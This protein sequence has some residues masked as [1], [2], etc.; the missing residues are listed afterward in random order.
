MPCPRAPPRSSAASASPRGAARFD[1]AF[2]AWG[3]SCGV[4]WPCQVPARLGPR[5]QPPRP[6]GPSLRRGS[7]VP[8]LS[9]TAARSARLGRTPGFPTVSGYT[10]GPARRRGLGCGRVLPCFGSAL[11]PRVPS[12]LR[13][14]ER[15]GPHP[16]CTPAP[17]A[18]LRSLRSRLLHHTRHR[19]PSGEGFRRFN[20]CSRYATARVLA[21]PPG[22]IRPQEPAL[23]GRRGL[24]PELPRG[25]VALSA[26]RVV[27]HGTRGGYRD[28]TCTGWRT[29]VTGCARISLHLLDSRHP[30]VRS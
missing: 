12:P 14:E 28:R 9:A 16:R 27:L 29:A 26:S 20:R 17:R 4:C 18:F 15:Q 7:S 30:V 11:R 2:V 10:G 24:L 13:R 8:S 25:E 21:R 6:T 5:P 1:M 19:L 23:S 22:P 3:P